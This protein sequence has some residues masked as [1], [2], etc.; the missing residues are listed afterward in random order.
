MGS[1][2]FSSSPCNISSCELGPHPGA[3]VWGMCDGSF[4]IAFR[5]AFRW[6]GVA[7][8]CKTGARHADFAASFRRQPGETGGVVT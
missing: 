1:W 8:W 3:Q 4:F 5:N 6:V 2:L 7:A